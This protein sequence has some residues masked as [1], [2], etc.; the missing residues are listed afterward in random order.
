L[1]RLGDPGTRPAA[2]CKPEHLG[3]LPEYLLHDAFEVIGDA[4]AASAEEARS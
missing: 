2:G 4:F 1:L 3:E